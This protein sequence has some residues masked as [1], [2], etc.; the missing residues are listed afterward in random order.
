MEEISN[1]SNN[2]LGVSNLAVSRITG[3]I[4]LRFYNMRDDQDRII[5]DACSKHRYGRCPLCAKKSYSVHSHYTRVLIDRPICGKRMM[6]QLATRKFRCSNHKCPQSVFSEQIMGITQRYG[7]KTSVAL[8]FLQKML[9]EMSSNKASFITSKIGIPQSSSTCLRIVKSTPEKIID[10]STVNRYVSLEEVPRKHRVY[11]NDYNS[12]LPLIEDGINKGLCIKEIYQS[13]FNSG[14]KV[15]LSSFYTWFETRFKN[16]AKQLPQQSKTESLDQVSQSVK[17]F[18]TITYMKLNLYVCNPNYG[19]NKKTGEISKERLKFDKLIE[20]S[21]ILTALK[22]ACSAFRAA[23]GGDNVKTLDE[24]IDKYKESSLQELKN[25]CRGI[26]S[27]YDAIKNT[28]VTPYS[29]GLVEGVN[30]KI[31]AIKRSMYGR[32]STKL[33]KIKMMYAYTG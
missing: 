31:K 15:A 1:R 7:R 21:P 19:I 6:I 9:I 25:F 10:K 20:S 28:I 30:N 27:D 16:Y 18:K 26:V 14:L 4:G 13:V 11:K 32:A 24:W 33:L 23:I 17:M 8:C 22:D 2:K 3:Y 12:R 29:N 5:V